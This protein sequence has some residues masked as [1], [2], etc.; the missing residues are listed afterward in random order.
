MKKNISFIIMIISIFNIYKAF[1]YYLWIN[2]PSTDIGGLFPKICS[3]GFQFA[4][5]IQIINIF[6]QIFILKYEKQTNKIIVI[7]LLIIIATL[8]IPVCKWMPVGTYSNIYDMD[9]HIIN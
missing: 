4:L 6:L 7:S 5:V 1:S 8:F 3:M 2:T 9:I